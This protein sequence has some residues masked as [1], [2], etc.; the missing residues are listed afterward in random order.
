MT[1]QVLPPTP[2]FCSPDCAHF[3]C[4]RSTP[5]STASPFECSP[6][7]CMK[8]SGIYWIGTVCRVEHTLRVTYQSLHF[9]DSPEPVA[10]KLKV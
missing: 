5:V 8:T 4:A 10:W 3:L 2:W 7:L 9:F 6:R 1:D